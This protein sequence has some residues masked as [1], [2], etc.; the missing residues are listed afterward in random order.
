[1]E[2]QPLLDHRIFVDT[3]EI[4]SPPRLIIFEQFFLVKVILYAYLNR[5]KPGVFVR[6]YLVNSTFVDFVIWVWMGTLSQRFWTA[7]FRWVY[8]VGFKVMI[9]RG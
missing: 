4:E 8:D 2:N 7:K 9:N 3:W 1:M 6:E 5:G